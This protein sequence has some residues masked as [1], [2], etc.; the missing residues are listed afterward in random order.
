MKYLNP[1]QTSAISLLK[2]SQAR[3]REKEPFVML[4]LL[5]LKSKADYSQTCLNQENQTTDPEIALDR[6]VSET[7]PFLNDS[8]GKLLLIADANNFFVGPENESWDKVMLVK[9]RSVEDFFTFAQNNDYLRVLAH[10]EASVED[11]RLLPLW[12]LVND[13]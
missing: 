4:N 10:R 7:L 1:T 8:G 13:Y 12:D 9:Q 3:A 6:Y 5:S 11:S 2:F